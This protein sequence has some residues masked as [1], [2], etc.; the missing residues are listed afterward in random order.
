[1][2]FSVTSLLVAFATVQSADAFIGTSRGY[3]QSSSMRGSGGLAPLMAKGDDD[4][5]MA[6][7]A[8]KRDPSEG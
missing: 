1:M 5:N 6:P 7:V 8:R 4:I 3:V 2:K